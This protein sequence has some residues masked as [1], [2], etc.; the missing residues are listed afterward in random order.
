[1]I[2]ASCLSPLVGQVGI[3][4]YFQT[5]V[6]YIATPFISVMVALPNCFVVA[7]KS[8]TAVFPS[9]FVQVDNAAQQ[10]VDQMEFSPAMNRDKPVGVWVAQRIDF[11]VSG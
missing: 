5:G 10:I 3:F 7:D 8:V 4:K 11:K 6:T 2:I 1:M 9:G